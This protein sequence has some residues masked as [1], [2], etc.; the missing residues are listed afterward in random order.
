MSIDLSLRVEPKTAENYDSLL[1]EACRKASCYPNEIQRLSILKKSL[2][3]RRRQIWVDLRV[4]LYMKGE[5]IV[6]QKGFF[7][8]DVH[9]APQVI[10][11]GA[12]PAGLFCAMQLIECGLKPVVLERGDDVDKRREKITRLYRDRQIDPDS[13]Y[14]F[15]E[16]G[17][18]TYSDGKLFTRSTKRGDVS[19]VLAAFVE[20]GARNE[21]L[22]EAHPHLGS[23]KLPKII[24]SI[25]KTILDCGGEFHFRTTV[26]GLLFDEGHIGARGVRTLGGEEFTGPVVLA[27]G[28]SATDV[29]SFLDSSGAG[30]ESKGIAVGVR[31]EHP[32]LL[33]DSI[34]YKNPNGR[35]LYLPPAEYSFVTQ[36]KGRGVYSFCMCPGGVVVPA[37]T[38]AGQMVVNGMSASSRSGRWANAAM[39]VEIRPED[40]PPRFGGKLGMQSFVQALEK[41]SWDFAEGSFSAPSQRMGDFVDQVK[42]RELNPTSYGLGTVSVDINSLLPP[43]ISC[44]LREGFLSFNR[45]AGGFLTNDAML[46]ATET[47]TSSPVRIVRDSVSLMAVNTRG[48]FPCGEGAGYAGGIVSSALDGMNS[49]LAVKQYLQK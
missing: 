11:V 9:S 15:G 26:S 24:A 22:Y 10:V 7:L 34:Q 27:C 42:S 18:G 8:N 19:K 5:E 1:S 48:L 2:D 45:S 3:S 14:C 20:N 25:R 28:H 44:R 33:I 12:G 32:Q 31:L 36:V 4:R 13:N 41:R 35:G 38:A 49:A 46:L 43:F 30:L 37:M 17:A 29:Y 6:E 21:I 47:R 40:L 39:V 16:G 23:D